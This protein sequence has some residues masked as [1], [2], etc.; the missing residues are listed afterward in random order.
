MI[1]SSYSATWT[2]ERNTTDIIDK[3]K[4]INFSKLSQEFVFW[5]Y[6]H[7]QRR[8]FIH[9]TFRNQSKEIITGRMGKLWIREHAS[10]DVV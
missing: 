2:L 1:V 10:K 8:R 7:T 6:R 4:K 9:V 5:L 3:I